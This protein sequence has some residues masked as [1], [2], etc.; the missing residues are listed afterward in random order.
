MM[1]KKLYRSRRDHI[2]AGVAGGLGEFFGIDATLVRL[3]MLLVVFAD[4]AGILLYIMAW[5]I[6]PVEPGDYEEKDSSLFSRSEALRRKVVS[7]AKQVEARLKG[8]QGESAGADG[9]SDVRSEAEGKEYVGGPPDTSWEEEEARRQRIGGL[10]LVGVGVL[11]FLR[12]FFPWIDISDMWPLFVI[13]LGL[14]L[15]LRGLVE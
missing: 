11:F 2:I 10:V 3:V 15:I 13:G 1:Q 7:G 8:R 5:V 9:R 14:L 12:N 4:G 6:I